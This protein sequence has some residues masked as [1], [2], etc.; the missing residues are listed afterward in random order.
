MSGNPLEELL[1]LAARARV[2]DLSFDLHAGVPHFPTHPP[3]VFGLTK[4]HGEIVIDLPDGR[5]ASSSADAI[6][7]GTHVGTHLD[8]LGHFSC[9]GMLFGDI[10]ASAQSYERGL[11]TYGVDT[12]APILRRGVLLDVAGLEGVPILPKDFSIG[13]QYLEAACQRQ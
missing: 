8:G 9:N 1:A 11:E 6:A 12:V 3:F 13:P 10:P 4:R 5:F 7:T 2:Y